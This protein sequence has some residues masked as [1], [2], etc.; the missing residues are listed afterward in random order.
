MNLLAQL[1]NQSPKSLAARLADFET[2]CAEPSLDVRLQTE[3][4]DVGRTK[5]AELG[6]DPKDTT[7]RELHHALLAKASHVEAQLRAALALDTVGSMY[8]LTPQIVGA[9]TKQK[10]AKSVWAIKSAA[11]KELLH[12]AP[13]KTVMKYLHYRSIDSMLKNE[14]A[15]ELYCAAR[16]SEPGRWFTRF[17]KSFSEL[18]STS[19]ESLKLKIIQFDSGKWRELFKQPAVGPIVSLPEVGAIA[20]TPLPLPSHPGS[21]LASWLLLNEA[22]AEVKYR[23]SYCK[24]MQVRT[25]FGKH[26]GKC[27]LA[28]SADLTIT[29][30]VSWRAVCQHF[31]AAEVMPSAFESHLDT[32]DLAI[33]RPENTL[34]ELAPSA[35]WWQG[36]YFTGILAGKKQKV[37]SMNLVD[38]SLDLVNGA[39]GDARSRYFLQRELADE[40]ALRYLTQ[41]AFESFVLDGLEKQL[42][43][44][45]KART[46]RLQTQKAV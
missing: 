28:S 16:L 30:G 40:L 46:L 34:L 3:V 14:N 10:F 8:E 29:K 44:K 6:L 9:F 31:T 18:E 41:P 27:L 39:S 35:G 22:A 26:V 33:Q 24:L 15:Y 20:I 37:A 32:S 23:S 25:D 36:T 38:L 19:F 7:G 1:L 43:T 4:Q 5:L 11:L 17:T 2:L 13:P 12:A 42:T 21:V 45:V